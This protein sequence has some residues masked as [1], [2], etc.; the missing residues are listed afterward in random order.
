MLFRIA[1]DLVV[2]VH[3]GFIIYVVIGGMTVFRDARWA[4]LHLPAV[5][6]GT[7]IELK[8]WVCP[9]TPLENRL[10]E[11]GGGIPYPGD[12]IAHYLIPVI[13]PAGLSRNVQFVLALIVL[14][15]NLII[16]GYYGYRNHSAGHQ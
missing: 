13:Y 15:A 9:L 7:V 14:A 1:A 6:W 10:R 5:A 8:G 11:L 3:F 12:F 4:A 16:Y 2:L